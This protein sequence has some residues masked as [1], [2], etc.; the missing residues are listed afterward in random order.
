MA[1]YN[2][3]RGSEHQGL[4]W[5]LRFPVVYE[6]IQRAMGKNKLRRRFVREY[7]EAR[8]GERLLDI[9][10][11]P[12]DLS[13]FCHD[14]DYIGFDVNRAYINSAQRRFGDHGAFHTGAIDQLAEHLEGSCDITVVVGVLHH[15]SDEA[16][17]ELV[18]AA[19]RC[20]REGGRFI[21]VEPHVYAGQH[22]VARALITHDRGNF[23]RDE[24][25]YADLI[26]TSFDD[27]RTVRDEHLLW[28]PYTL[29]VYSARKKR[30][31]ELS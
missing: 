1:A 30:S 7:V 18:K 28:V 10:C 27:V 5:W 20:L 13:T 25:S 24:A 15:V 3:S 2:S 11:G 23:V 19:R 16:A 14:V 4:E 26:A 6:A 17:V 21:A 12:G 29:S 22:P 8:S 31:S 9:G